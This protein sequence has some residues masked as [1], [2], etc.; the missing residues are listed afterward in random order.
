MNNGSHSWEQVRLADILSYAEELVE[1]DDLTQYR[2]IT[3]KRRHGG[4][5]ERERLF[6]HQIKTKKQFRLIPGAFIISRIQCW[7]QAY[8]IVPDDIPKTMIASQN[9]DQ[10]TISPEVDRRY[11]W[12]FSHSPLFTETVRS[13]AFGVV[14]EKMVFNRDA[15]LEKK[16]PLPSPDEQRRIVSRIEELAGKIEEAQTLRQHAME[17]SLALLSS[18]RRALFGD[19]PNSNWVPLSYFVAAIENGKSPQCESR[20]ANEDEWGVLKVGAVSF[21]SFDEHENKALPV[22][23]KFD[24]RYEVQSGDFLMSRANTTELVGACA[25]VGRTRPRLLLSDKTFRFH[26]R[27]DVQTLPEWLDHAMKSPALREQIERKA[28]GTSPTMKNISKEK[29][30]GLL[31]PPHSL[32]EQRKV[33]SDLN[34]LQTRV[35]TVK[36]LHL[37]TT[38]ELD[39]LMPSVL[40]KAFRG[41]L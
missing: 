37:E 20:P 26:F 10:F 5:E 28:S 12:W 23:L 7:H 36:L 27:P 39:A 9:Y 33:V 15:W 19:V 14:I 16:I 24:S 34:E 38:A 30:Y 25:I 4:L 8:A 41:E 3:V 40:S 17:E 6:G 22:G 18:T 1:L 11:F 13:S 21:G 32:P 31:L 35:N 29:V 2:T